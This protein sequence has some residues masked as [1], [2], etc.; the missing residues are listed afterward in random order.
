M[1]S[2]GGVAAAPA[3]YFLFNLLLYYNPCLSQHLVY[4]NLPYDNLTYNSLVYNNLFHN[5]LFYND[6]KY[7]NFADTVAGS[8]GLPCVVCQLALADG[9][10]C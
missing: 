7:N 2:V 10:L 3:S 1:V 8:C 6:L 4:N 9:H 5:N